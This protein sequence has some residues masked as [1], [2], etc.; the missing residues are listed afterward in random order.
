M[1][2]IRLEIE[3]LNSFESRQILEFDKLGDGVF[4]I[5]GNTGSG[6]ST[7]LDAITLALYG[8]I[9]R[10]K[11]Q[12]DFV[13]I[14]RQKASV[15][16][17]FEISEQ[18]KTSIYQVERNFVRKKNNKQI[19]SSAV[20]YKL[21]GDEKQLVEEGTIRVN[22]KIFSIIGLGANE[23]AKCIALPQG[24]FSAFLQAKPSERIEIMSNIFNLTKYGDRLSFAV[25][26]RVAECDKEVSVLL[27][28]KQMLEGATDDAVAIERDREKEAKQIYEA[29][30]SKLKL[31]SEE[32]AKAQKTLERKETLKKIENELAQ[33][34]TQRA[35]I[36]ELEKTTKRAQNANEMKT[37]FFK[38]KKTQSDEKE[39]SAKLADLNELKLKKQTEMLQ[40]QQEFEDLK[41]AYETKLPELTKKI[42]NLE[43]LLGSDSEIERLKNEQEKL[44][45]EISK[46]QEELK[47]QQES[48]AYIDSQLEQLLLKLASVDEFIEKN[49]PEVERVYALEQVKDIESEFILIEDF[50]QKI[51]ALIDNL[52]AELSQAENGYSE[53]VKKDKKLK[54]KQE[55]IKD[56][57]RV[58]FEDD[59]IEPI[60]KLRACDRELLQFSEAESL[61]AHFE[62]VIKKLEEDSNRRLDVV[63]EVRIK[64]ERANQNLADYE[65]SIRLKENEIATLSETREE[66]LG[67]NVISLISDNLKIGDFCPVCSARVIQKI[68]SEKNNL[69]QLENQIFDER[70]N[71]KDMDANR[72]KLLAE[73]VSLKA[74]LEFEKAQIEANDS[75]IR[76]I[77][78]NISQIFKKFVDD[79]DLKQE[80]F[81][82]L[83]SLIIETSTKLEDLLILQ[84]R[85]REEELF[86]T[87]KKAEFGAQISI[88]KTQLEPL[89]ELLHDLQKKKAEREFIILNS[90]A[91]LEKIDN[92]KKFVADGKNL[93]IEVDLKIKAKQQL[94]DDQLK[95][96]QEK[97]ELE[98]KVLQTKSTLQVL[99]QKLEG[100]EKQ[101]ANLIAKALTSGVPEGVSIADEIAFSKE[102]IARLK[103][104]YSEKQSL[105]ET[106]NETFSRIENDYRFTMAILKD[107]QQEKENLQNIIQNNM[108]KFNFSSEDEV[109]KLFIENVEIKQNFE[110]INIFNNKLEILKQQKEAINESE[111]NEVDEQLILKFK[112][113]AETLT[114][115]VK[116]LS[117]EIG[118]IGAKLEAVASNNKKLKEIENA[119]LV[120]Q[121]KYDTAKEL[122]S[123]LRGKALAEYFCEE[124]LQEITESANSKLEL[125]MD[126]RYTLKFADKEFFVEDNFS[127]GT[128]RAASTLSGGETFVVSL[129]LALSISDAIAMLSSRSIDFFFLDEGFGTLDS[130]LCG[131]VVSA[132]HKL[133][134]QNL[135][136]GLISHIAELAE[137]I[138]NKVIVTKDAT[139]SKI[140]IEHSL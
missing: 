22:E 10:S 120:A 137:A 139:G 79:N 26:E 89:Y 106:Y 73:V 140:K 19:D 40:A 52:S 36:E 100:D 132:L 138:K 66:M 3:G 7:I 108:V 60:E 53:A 90:N 29:R 91:E 127:D 58:A 8:K 61:I 69:S 71:K 110:K 15:L 32:I 123:V 38:F 67:E 30:S 21:S 49:K 28:S 17:S 72:D 94:R 24:E 135:K 51:D 95:L 37:D 113:E 63:A 48:V 115:E 97:G 47:Q 56:S 46:A 103:K 119:L 74:R 128:V 116:M 33:L 109:E 92:Y 11:Q 134:S 13:N 42:S 12:I 99:N 76:T 41:N 9:E 85:L 105:F 50:Y 118:K 14:K 87:S 101:I 6:K 43:A 129:S 96:V 117:E 31:L 16:L 130:E 35:S 114:E 86:V 25:K 54:T 82:R 102:A 80:N 18:G 133:E 55:E 59:E 62:D 84:E 44:K 2:P 98:R 4:G 78:G 131:V 34:E 111:I 45:L 81:S 20:L 64:I 1:K 93:E 70:E 104:D 68:Y 65:R 23:F 57:F 88:L 122:S 125:L 27:A 77:N 107:K 5:F 126:G 136:I 39:L 83:K 121:K 112:A 124:Y 75:E